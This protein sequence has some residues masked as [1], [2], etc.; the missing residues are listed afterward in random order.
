MR[1]KFAGRVRRLIQWIDDY[2]LHEVEKEMLLEPLDEFLS[3]F[4]EFGFLVH[5]RKALS[6]LREARFCGGIPR[7]RTVT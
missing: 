5:A 2:L 4:S 6:F 3:V 1:E 7:E